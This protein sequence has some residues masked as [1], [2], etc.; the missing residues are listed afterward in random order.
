VQTVERYEPRRSHT[1]ISSEPRVEETRIF[2][3][4]GRQRE[5]LAEE[6]LEEE[7]KVDVVDLTLGPDSGT[8]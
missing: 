6:E 1:N 4:L 7:E 2:P 8:P 5:I 3:A